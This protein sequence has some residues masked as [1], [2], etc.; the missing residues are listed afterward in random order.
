MIGEGLMIGAAVLR[1][2]LTLR[3]I[4]KHLFYKHPSQ[5]FKD[6]Y[7]V[8]LQHALQDQFSTNNRIKKIV[9]RK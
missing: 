9:Q 8:N 3:D 7:Q 2:G 6:A 1:G 4:Q 5:K